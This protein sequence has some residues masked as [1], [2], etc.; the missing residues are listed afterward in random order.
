MELEIFSK[1]G[2]EERPRLSTYHTLLLDLSP[3]ID[4]IRKNLHKKWRNRL[5]KSEK[6]NLEIIKGTSD[7]LFQKFKLLYDEMLGRKK[8]KT[9]IDINEFLNIQ[10]QLPDKYKMYIVL[11]SLED[12]IVSGAVFSYIG[13]FGI[14]LL[15]ATANIG[16]EAQGSY[17][18]QW[19]IIELLKELGC[20]WYD[21][22][23]VDKAN[24]PHVYHFKSGISNNEI[25]HLAQYEI[26]KTILNR[27][28]MK[29]L[30]FI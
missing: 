19:K 16:L 10:K 17:F 26:G 8:F 22:G 4:E 9:T 15:G 20:K 27:L 28:L 3:P 14:Y 25:E 1:L 7:E 18:I 12:Q 23:G 29:L 5:N 13:D 6:N 21:L 2:F 30:K 11:C 24:N